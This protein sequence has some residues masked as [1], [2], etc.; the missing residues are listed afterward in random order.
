MIRPGGERTV[1]HRHLQ[2]ASWCRSAAMVG[3]TPPPVPAHAIRR[4]RLEQ[5]LDDHPD[6]QVVLVRGPV[7]VGKT[8]LVAQWVAGHAGPCA[9]IAI[10]ATDDDGEVLRRHLADAE[11]QLSPNGLTS[12][13]TLVL[14]DVHH[15]HDHAALHLLE[16]LVE[17]P[18]TG[19][20]LV[21]TSRS[22]PRLGLERARL[23]GDLVEI[24]PAALRFDARRSTPW[25]RPGPASILALPISSKRPSDGP[26]G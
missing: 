22:K 13:A 17:H 12:M 26:R 8:V 10:D 15:L 11:E 19:V 21:L 3:G 25:L 2:A 9:W 1:L 5:L 24:V 7:G 16:L 18:P 23:R 6:R 20:R 4:P 14:D